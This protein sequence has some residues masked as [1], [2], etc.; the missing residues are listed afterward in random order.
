MEIRVLKYFLAVAREGNITKAADMLHITQPTLS[1]QLM[2]LEDELGA[3]LFVRGKRKIV[4][5]DA[6]MLL[7]RRAEEIVSLSERTELEIGNQDNEV[8]GEIVLACGITE[9]TKTMGRYIK[10]FN[11]LYP[12]VTFRIRNGN[13]DFMLESIENGI[14]D[15]GFVIEPVNLEKLNFLKLNTPEVWGILMKSDSSLAEKEYVSVSDL[16]NIPLINTSRL[17]TQNLFRAWVGDENYKKLHFSAISDLT[18]TASIL[19]ENDIGYAI[20]IEGAVDHVTRQNL[21]FR[22]FYPKLTSDS[23]V[24]WKKYQ[25]FSFTISKFIDFI[26]KEIKENR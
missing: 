6:G 20:V 16:I 24:V 3:A 22:P 1:R 15:I 21:C 17:E 23:L 25:S 4:L 18:T 5:T 14:V 7:K 19:V 2:Q 11:R 9:A 26:S 12:Q 10:E 8:S 13:S